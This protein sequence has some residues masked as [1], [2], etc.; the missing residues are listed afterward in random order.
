[1][2]EDEV[3]YWSRRLLMKPGMTGWAQVRCGYATDCASS[4]EKLSYDFWYM[5]HSNLAVDFAVCFARCCWR[6][7][8]STRASCRLRRRRP[9]SG[10]RARE[11]GAA[12]RSPPRVLPLLVAAVAAAAPTRPPS[13]APGAGTR[14]RPP[15]GARALPRAARR[16]HGSPARA[17]CAPRWPPA[18]AARSCSRPARYGG[19]RPFLNPHGH[20]L[21]AARLGRAVLSAGLSL[22][23]NTGR[24]GGL[25]RG[26]V[27]DVAR[28]RRT[29]DGAA[30]VVWGTGRGS[31][32]LDTTVRGH[33]RLRAGVAARRPEG[34]VDAA[35]R[36][37]PVPGLRRAGRRQRSGPRRAARAVRD[38]R[39]R[40][41]R[42]SPGRRPARRRGD[43]RPASGSATPACC[44]ACARARARGPGCGPAPRRGAPASR[45]STST[46]RAPASTSSTSP[47]TARSARLRIGPRRARRAHRRMGRP[48]LGRPPGERR[49]RDRGQPLREPARRR[50]PRR[51]DDAHDRAA[52]LVRRP[53]V[54][55]R[56]ATTAATGTPSTATTTRGRPRGVRHDHLSSAREG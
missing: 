8:S 27:V 23:G 29:V 18:A 21:Y 42:T 37:A 56:S 34:L 41:R 46:A 15:G 16:G 52:E 24:G 28:P 7:R 20:R 51:G 19:P 54:G 55:R 6:S 40:R 5:R 2:L 50:L 31:R 33:G 53:D 30:I 22:G 13:R 35:R 43:P 45:R 25:V 32:I 39:R 12:R 38:Q 49:Q 3:P 36:R 14:R 44:G 4:A 17:S 47:A 26:L 9:A 1:M 10:T 48:R 11:V